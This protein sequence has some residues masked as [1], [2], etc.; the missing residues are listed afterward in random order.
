MAFIVPRDGATPDYA[1]I[2]AWCDARMPAFMVP[3]YF[4]TLEELPR[5]PTEKVRKK[6]LREQGVGP[7]TW[8]RTRQAG[9]GS[10]N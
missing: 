4:D 6:Q 5:T 7:R 2:A 8:D 3:R 1:D 10:P 9:T